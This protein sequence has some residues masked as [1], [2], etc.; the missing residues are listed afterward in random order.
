VADLLLQQSMEEK[1]FYAVG[2][3]PPP[4]PIRPY[5]FLYSSVM[6]KIHKHSKLWPTPKPKSKKE[7]AAL[8]LLHFVSLWMLDTNWF[9]LF[10]GKWKTNIRV[11]IS[12]IFS[13][14]LRQLL[15]LHHVTFIGT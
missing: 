15:N 14:Q 5:F 12:A 7:R 13:D 8:L 1:M 9:S 3:P 2:Q 6:L 11:F 4:S 10:S